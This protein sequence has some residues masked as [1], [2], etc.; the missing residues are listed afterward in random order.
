MG[1]E[2][3]TYWVAVAAVNVADEDST[4]TTATTMATT[5][6]GGSNDDNG[7]NNNDNTNKHGLGKGG[8]TLTRRAREETNT[9]TMDL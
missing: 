1:I 9:E 2:W 8:A 4:K 6:D 3:K 7:G 5:S